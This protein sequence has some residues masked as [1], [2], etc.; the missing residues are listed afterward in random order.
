MPF[1]FVGG[2]VAAGEMIATVCLKVVFTLRVMASW[3]NL[4]RSVRTTFGETTRNFMGDEWQVS[5]FY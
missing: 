4:T 2:S 1:I 3:M 5:V